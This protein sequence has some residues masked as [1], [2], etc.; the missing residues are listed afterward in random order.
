VAVELESRHVVD[1][2][3]GDETGQATHRDLAEDLAQDAALH[4]ADRLA[5][6]LERDLHVDRLI[7]RDLHEVGVKERAGDRVV[8]EIS[9]QHRE[10]LLVAH[11]ELDDAVAAVIAR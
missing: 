2:L 8:L 11:V 9:E 7:E 5:R 3:D 10:L 1:D 4:D 6:R